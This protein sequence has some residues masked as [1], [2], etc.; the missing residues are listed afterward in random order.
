MT[1]RYANRSSSGALFSSNI[2]NVIRP[3][4]VSDANRSKAVVLMLIDSVLFLLFLFCL[5]IVF[6]EV[7]VFNS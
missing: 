3:Q 4:V 6:C 7:L 5:V 1:G 2:D